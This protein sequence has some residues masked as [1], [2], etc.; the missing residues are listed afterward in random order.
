MSIKVDVLAPDLEKQIHLLRQTDKILDRQF[1]GAMTR[2][3][4]NTYRLILPNVPR[5]RTGK[6]AGS[7]RRDVFGYGRTLAGVV[8]WFGSKVD[9]WY[10]NIVEHGAKPHSLV[11]GSKNRSKAQQ[12]RLTK[13]ISRGSL[14]TAHVNVN[15]RWVSM[16]VHPG[17]S[18]RGFMEKG[19]SSA[20]PLVNAEFS[21]AADAALAEQVVR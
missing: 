17:F 14:K 11:K 4:E 2:S 5:G 1:A 6:A 3:V 19:F 12:E 20:Q 15:G 18:Q 9:A 16:Q 10:I 7:F 13:R 21:R 8:G